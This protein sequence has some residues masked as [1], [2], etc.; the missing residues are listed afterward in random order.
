MLLGPMLVL[1]IADM[2]LTAHGL[3]RG[4]REINF[5][6]ARLM[7]RIGVVPGMLVYEGAL[8]ALVTAVVVLFAGQWALPSGIVIEIA[9]AV[10]RNGRLI[11]N[12]AFPGTLEIV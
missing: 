6:A 11:Q 2:V 12:A 3:S 10:E 1:M 9:I 5:I 4:F 7:D 8:F